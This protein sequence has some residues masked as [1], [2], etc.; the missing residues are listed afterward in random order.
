HFAFL[1][2]LAL[3]GL[4]MR[5]G[6]KYQHQNIGLIAAGVAFYGLLS[7]FP[8]ITALV[9]IAGLLTDPAILIEQGEQ[10]A[11]ALPSDARRIIFDQVEKVVTSDSGTLSLTVF[12]GLAI[13][14]FSA[15]RAVGSLIQGLNLAYGVPET[16]GFFKLRFRILLLTFCMI[17][18]VV[19]ALA[20][21]AVLPALLAFLPWDLGIED[22]L[23]ALRWIVLFA[24]AAL[25]INFLYRFGPA[26]K[27]GSWRW[28]TV[29]S[30]VATAL[31]LLGN[32]GFSAYVQ[33][34]GT[35]GEVFGALGGVIV[36]LT[37]LWLSAVILLVGALVDF[38]IKN[39]RNRD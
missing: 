2:G 35:Y 34:F 1:P 39:T 9:A 38:E 4:L 31:W 33:S 8:A 27:L 10:L 29:G 7:L 37:W 11:T 21:V 3:V 36:L 25:S 28:F 26:Q 13:A 18:G 22:T 20:L 24:L 5:V 19:A 30:L 23:L 16:R 14:V 32:F 15:S 6:S 17:I 12:I